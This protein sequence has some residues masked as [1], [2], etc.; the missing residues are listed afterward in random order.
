M[1]LTTSLFNQMAAIAPGMF[2]G[3]RHLLFG[4]EAADVVVRSPGVSVHRPELLA[5]REGGVPVTTATGL[6]LGERSGHAV[7][8][9][10][11]TKG[12]STTAALAAHLARAAGCAA[13][14]AGNIGVPAL[15]L[16]DRDPQDLAVVELS[17]YQIADLETGPQM[18]VITTVLSVTTT[19]LSMLRASVGMLVMA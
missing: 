14:L 1:F 10:T 17:S 11:G 16:L 9:V 12:K 13:H 7:I 3:V 2:S 5:L 6:W 8:G 18:V 19:L 15:D 4:G